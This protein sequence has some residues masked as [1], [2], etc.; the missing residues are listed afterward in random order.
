VK[1]RAALTPARQFCGVASGR[2]SDGRLLTIERRKMTKT[3]DDNRSQELAAI[4]ARIVKHANAADESLLH[5]AKELVAVKARIEGGE[6]GNIKWAKWSSENLSLGPTRIRELLKIGQAEND[7]AELKRQRDNNSER[8]K[9][10]RDKKTEAAP[11]SSRR[12]PSIAEQASSKKET[13]RNASERLVAWANEAPEDQVQ[14]VLDFIAKL[15]TAA[16]AR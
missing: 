7:E 2:K 11:A 14:K 16:S 5:A 4:A 6:F 15:Q 3:K 10:H 8:Q 9:R 12:S 13:L 1:F